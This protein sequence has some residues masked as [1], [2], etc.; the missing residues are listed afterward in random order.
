MRQK[1]KNLLFSEITKDTIKS[2]YKKL[3]NIVKYVLDSLTSHNDFR[4]KLFDLN[5]KL[6]AVFATISSIIGIYSSWK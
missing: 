4:G 1:A 2:H 3:L 6:N 5:P